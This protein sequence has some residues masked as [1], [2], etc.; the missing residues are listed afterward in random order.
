MRILNVVHVSNSSVGLA[1]LGEAHKAET[2]A[3]TSVTVLDDNLRLSV[4]VAWQ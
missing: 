4:R 3:A 1:V 2:T